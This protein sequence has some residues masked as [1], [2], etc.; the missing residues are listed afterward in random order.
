MVGLVAVDLVADDLAPADLVPADSALDDSVA[1]DSPL[2]GWFR[3]DCSVARASE[4]ADL[5]P[6]DRAEADSSPGDWLAQV[7]YSARR[8]WVR[9]DSRKAA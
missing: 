4:T 3:D 1:D 5:V 6:D 8:R 2:A 7:D 9:D